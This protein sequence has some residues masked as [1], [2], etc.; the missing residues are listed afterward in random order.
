MSVMLKLSFHFWEASTWE[1]I[2]WGKL[3]Q[4]F[5]L[6]W[7][8]SLWGI[9]GYPLFW[10]PFWMPK[11]IYTVE[12]VYNCRASYSSTVLLNRRCSA[13]T[14]IYCVALMYLNFI[15]LFWEPEFPLCVRGLSGTAC[16]WL[17][18]EVMWYYKCCRLWVHKCQPFTH[19]TEWSP[20]LIHWT[21]KTCL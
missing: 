14:K 2:N 15:H 6:T 10:L 3:L 16:F 7:Q 20:A 13:S 17:C 12:V 8:T 1:L 21:H 9:V 5:C 4:A 18:K 11:I 19:T